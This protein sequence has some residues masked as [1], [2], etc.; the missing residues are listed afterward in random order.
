MQ[1]MATVLMIAAMCGGARQMGLDAGA[2]AQVAQ[3]A[4]VVRV[5]ATLGSP[6]SDRTLHWL[7]DHGIAFTRLEMG[8]HRGEVFPLLQELGVIAPVLVQRGETLL[9][10]FDRVDLRRLFSTALAER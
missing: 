10:G 6:E 1:T 2:D 8:E 4:P 9:A 3:P 7:A 5:Y